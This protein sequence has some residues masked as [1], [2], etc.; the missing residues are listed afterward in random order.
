MINEEVKL[1]VLKSTGKVTTQ[2]SIADEVG[3]SVG[4]VNYILKGL[5]EKGLIK[6]ERF[7][8]S[9][10]KLQYKYLLTEAGIKEK[11][12]ITERFIIRKK[13]EYDQ[14]QAEMKQYKEQYEK[15]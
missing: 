12:D 10:N 1:A 11:M 4:K 5:M 2:K 3:Y 14:L 15:V 8:N 6:A 9:N 13:E 7:M